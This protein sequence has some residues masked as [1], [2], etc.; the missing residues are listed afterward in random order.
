MDEDL[1]RKLLAEEVAAVRDG[2][3]AATHR[4]AEAEDIFVRTALG[5]TLP[6]FFTTGAYATHLIGRRTR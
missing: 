6:P 5:E 2:T 1:V 3:D 4:W